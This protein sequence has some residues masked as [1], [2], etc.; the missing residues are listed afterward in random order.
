MV[1]KMNSRRS[2][3]NTNLSPPSMML[4]ENGFLSIASTDTGTGTN[5]DILSAAWK[6]MP[7]ISLIKSKYLP[8]PLVTAR[9]MKRAA[10]DLNDRHGWKMIKLRSSMFK[11]SRKKTSLTKQRANVY[12]LLTRFPLKAKYIIHRPILISLLRFQMI[13]FWAHLIRQLTSSRPS[14]VRC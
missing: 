10:F 5:W 4:K 14:S 6:N 2:D 13:C 7:G 9:G 11:Y 1:Q 3:K 12:H 8:I